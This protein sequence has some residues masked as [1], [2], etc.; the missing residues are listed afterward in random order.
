VRQALVV[1]WE[2][3]DRIC[4]KRLQLLIPVL[5]DAMARHGHL[6]PDHEVQA[7][8]L[9][10]SAATID[11]ALQLTRLTG[12]GKRRRPGMG[13]VLVRKLVTVR[14]FNDWGDPKP[15]YFE[16]DLVQHCGGR[17]EGSFVHSFVLTDIA[18]AGLNA[19][20]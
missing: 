18:S 15:G 8:L 11:R 17:S 2:A 3:S 1:L 9:C 5:L 6:R 4:G 12:K 13:A 20:R 14:T 19:W 10:M 7:Q 16:A